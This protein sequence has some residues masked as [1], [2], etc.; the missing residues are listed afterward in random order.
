MSDSEQH[1]I[2][3][4]NCKKE[5]DTQNSGTVCPF[6]GKRASFRANIAETVERE[7]TI[8]NNK[9]GIAIIS[10]TAVMG[11]AIIIFLLT[12]DFRPEPIKDTNS[13]KNNSNKVEM[14]DDKSGNTKND[15]MNIDTSA[16]QNNAD[17]T[18]EQGIG[19]LI[20]G[21]GVDEYGKQ[22]VE[23]AK[24][25]KRAWPSIKYML[26]AIT[27]LGMALIIIKVVKSL[28]NNDKDKYFWE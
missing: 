7:E 16:N 12:F 9:A 22:Y 25:I 18:I 19:N 2:R 21:Y 10:F 11:I 26:T 13:V 20:G 27:A 3:C 23:T 28:S 15:K 1:L 14:S 6:C 24:T 8:K 17:E 4:S 5:F